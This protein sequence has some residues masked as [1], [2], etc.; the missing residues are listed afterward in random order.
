MNEKPDHTDWSLSE[1]I[2]ARIELEEIG[3]PARQK[4]LTD[5]VV[6]L[7][8]VI[9]AKI[10]NDAVQVSYDPLATSEKNI[11]QAV[12]STGSTVKAATTGT[13]A[14]HPD[15][16]TSVNPEQAPV[17]NAAKTSTSDRRN[18]YRENVP[19]IVRRW[20]LA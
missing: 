9:E 7:N 12:R 3:D 20:R 14:A 2:A 15:L 6:A 17:Q 5:A 1:T 10:D 19:T 13:E 8:G 16:P 4:Q 18:L 11:E